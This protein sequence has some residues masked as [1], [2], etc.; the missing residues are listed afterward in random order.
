MWLQERV[1]RTELFVETASTSEHRCDAWPKPVDF[2][3]LTGRTAVEFRDRRDTGAQ[4]RIDWWY[5]RF[6]ARP[7]SYDRFGE[8]Y[9][10]RWPVLHDPQKIHESVASIVQRTFEFYLYKWRMRGET[11][12]TRAHRHSVSGNIT[13]SSAGSAAHLSALISEIVPNRSAHKHTCRSGGARGATFDL[14]SVTVVDFPRQE[15]NSHMC[16]LVR[17]RGSDP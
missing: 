10:R 12:S 5:I 3:R 16:T 15:R 4:G 2:E 9:R 6:Y 17:M 1:S 14:H 8:R 11:H 13:P 7:P